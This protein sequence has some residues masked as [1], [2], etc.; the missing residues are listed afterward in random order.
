MDTDLQASLF[1]I[2]WSPIA[3]ILLW[4]FR[5]SYLLQDLLHVWFSEL[6][7]EEMK[8]EE[9]NSTLENIRKE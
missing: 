2:I 9:I 8:Q 1:L 4:R 7:S 3:E 6:F 5:Y